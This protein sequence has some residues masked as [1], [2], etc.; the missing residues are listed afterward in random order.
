[1]PSLQL[2]HAK[3]FNNQPKTAHT[4]RDKGDMTSKSFMALRKELRQAH[5]QLSLAKEEA[6]LARKEK[7]IVTLDLKQETQRAEQLKKLLQDNGI[8]IPEH[9]QLSKS[10]KP[11]PKMS[12]QLRRTSSAVMAPPKESK[13]PVD[14]WSSG[15]KKVVKYTAADSQEAIERLSSQMVPQMDIIKPDRTLIQEGSCVIVDCEMNEVPSFNEEMETELYKIYLFTDA[16]LL[17]QVVKKKKI[18]P[19]MWLPL[20][21]ARLECTS[22]E[23]R[24]RWLICLDSE[25]QAIRVGIFFA[26]RKLCQNW[27]EVIKTQIK[28]SRKKVFF[29][30]PLESLPTTLSKEG[31][32]IPHLV[33]ELVEYLRST[34]LQTE[35]MF[36]LAGTKTT[37]EEIR[38][39]IEEGGKLLPKM[40]DPHTLGDILKQWFR[41][42]P[43]PVIPFSS[44]RSFLDEFEKGEDEFLAVVG[45]LLNEIPPKNLGLL[46][47]LCQYLSE[48]SKYSEVNMMTTDNLSTCFGPNLLRPEGEFKSAYE[49]LACNQVVRL[50][51]ENW[52]KIPS[53]KVLALPPVLTMPPSPKPGSVSPK[54][55]SA[56]PKGAQK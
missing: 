51:I 50:L 25:I 46:R 19:E 12:K 52:E 37:A 8:A 2:K 1:M 13:P 35:G 43:V 44:F 26:D 6:E 48:I 49:P 56:S 4:E 40:Y 34:A 22:E 16:V 14:F 30:V 20:A 11:P 23:L 31:E 38:D 28:A 41:E 9:L 45:D 24:R 18:R 5:T 32:N 39:I 54:S 55:G 21:E 3:T 10:S 7:E 15:D 36:R 27:G 47:Y 42:L 53:P 29:G 33:H 17:A